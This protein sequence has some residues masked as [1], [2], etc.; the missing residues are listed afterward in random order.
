M[1]IIKYLQSQGIGS[2][3]VC[4]ALLANNR[5]RINGEIPP[6]DMADPATPTILTIDG[7]TV[8]ALPLPHFYIVLNK[9]ANFETSHKPQHYPSVF[10]L[11]PLNWQNLDI[12]AVGRLDADTTG[13]LLLTNDGKL[14]HFLTSP[15]NHIVKTYVATLKHP[16]DETLCH[17]LTDGVLLHDDNETVAALSAQLRTPRELLLK[18]D[19]G[20]YHQVKRMIA[21]CRNRVV[22]LERTAFGNLTTD[23]IKQGEWRII[24]KEEVI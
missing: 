17:Q 2:R 16:A 6:D 15:K 1:N 13:V 8:P 7:E 18:I 5:V 22:H 10:S 14:N 20:K 3:K 4:Q 9:P 19:S 24:Q 11:L 21:A 23:G 12:Q